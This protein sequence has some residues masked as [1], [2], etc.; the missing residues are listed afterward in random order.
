MIGAVIQG[1][2]LGRLVKLFGDK[3]LVVTGTAIFAASVC[4]FPLGHTVA[5]LI[6][7]STGIAVGNSLLTPTLNGLASK[8]VKASRQGRVLG[9]MASVAS[10]ARIIGPVLGGTLLGLD[11]DSSAHYGRTPYW[12][13]SAIMLIALG[14]AF[15]VR[16]G[17]ENAQPAARQIEP[18]GRA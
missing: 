16:T 12:T 8:S 1:G 10:L 7:A 2:L 11:S 17:E 5:S 18:E 6:I 15:T 3:P 14:L 13:S 9:L 4:Y